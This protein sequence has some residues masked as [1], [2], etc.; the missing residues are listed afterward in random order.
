MEKNPYKLWWKCLQLV[1]LKDWKASV[2]KD[3]GTAQSLSF[4][5]W[6]D[7]VGELLEEVPPF[8][9]R[10]I[11]TKEEAEQWS[12][13]ETD[14]L[15]LN[16]AVLLVNLAN[17]TSVLLADIEQKLKSLKKVKRGRPVRE[18]FAEYPLARLPNVAQINKLLD[19]FHARVIEE[20]K[21]W[22]VAVELRLAPQAK[23]SDADGKNILNAVAGRAVKQAHALIWNASQGSFPSY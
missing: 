21:L 8:I 15:G 5:D 1:P 11:D 14:E 17:P 22:E 18:S 16:E 6:W 7:E 13:W 19:V 12:L 20:K 9:S 23:P 10:V 3:L 2:R 4:E